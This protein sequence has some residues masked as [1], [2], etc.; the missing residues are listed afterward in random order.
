MDSIVGEVQI[1]HI[2]G[3]S[4]GTPSSRR[5]HLRADTYY[6][7]AGELA[8]DTG[9]SVVNQA[10]L[11][12]EDDFEDAHY[13]DLGELS[14]VDS[15]TLRNR[16][17]IP[18][19][20]MIPHFSWVYL[21]G[22]KIVHVGP[23]PFCSCKGFR[24]QPPERQGGSCLCCGLVPRRYKIVDTIA[25]FAENTVR[26][27]GVA[28]YTKPCLT[29][30]VL[31]YITV[32]KAVRRLRRRNAEITVSSLVSATRKPAKEILRCLVNTSGH[33]AFLGVRACYNR[34]LSSGAVENTVWG[35]LKYVQECG[36]P[37]IGEKSLLT[38]KGCAALI[39]G[40][41]AKLHVHWINFF[42]GAL[43][44]FKENICLTFLDDKFSD[45]TLVGGDRR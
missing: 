1:I 20:V 9:A 4:A 32:G 12:E 38:D 5:V 45:N 35:N 15:T 43:P 36:I 8:S 28:F 42:A 31:S 23:T 41:A 13:Y 16:R 18:E 37:F 26:S 3:T 10:K 34:W 30:T 17:G 6:W 39:T 22:S 2:E 14:W 33:I 44:N 21:N 19:G 7:L 25:L 11:D 24:H 40:D 29:P 27:E